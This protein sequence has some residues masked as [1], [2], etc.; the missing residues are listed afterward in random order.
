[1]RRVAILAVGL[2]VAV[3]ALW[4][5]LRPPTLDVPPPS[6]TLVDVTVV[7]P[8]RERRQVRTLQVRGGRVAWLGDGGI[9]PRGDVLDPERPHD[10]DPQRF[11]GMYVLPGL[12]DMHVHQPPATPLGDVE[13]AALLF[14]LHGVTAVR[15]TGSFD[16]AILETQRAIRLGEFPGP[17]IFAC[18]PIL[19]GD[20]P[21][22]SGSRVVRDAAE[23]RAAVDEL[24]AKKVDCV[25]V[26]DRLS[27]EALAAVREAAERHGLPVIGH[28]PAQVPFS[29]ARLADVQHLTGV[30]EAG[31]QLTPARER[32]I[33][34]ASAALGIAHTPTLVF[35]ERVSQLTD[36]RAQLA[37]PG[38]RLLPRYYREVL[39]N[40]EHDARL[41]GLSAGDWDGL[42]ET[43]ANAKRLV[44]A[45]H[46][47]GVEIHVGTDAMNPFVVPGASLHEEMWELVDAG[48][49]P[50]EVWI[51]ATRTAGKALGQPTLGT[52]AVGAP[53]DLL[54]FREDPTRDLNALQT[55]EAV[56]A[57]GRLYPRSTLQEALG[58]W[59]RHFD[60]P[61]Y[62]AVTM[63]LARW[64]I[65]AR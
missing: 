27:P 15:D 33:L 34:T 41:R 7:N 60:D 52:I 50:E 51:A 12:I 31:E 13:L 49:T 32:A 17:R 63:R 30:V 5:L 36:Y 28:V 61:V 10:P 35:L 54:V 6:T 53:A 20:P 40:P 21:F 29:E 47:A 18:G 23:A 16:G 3:A 4:S 11:A 48:L 24:A 9:A 8:G 38:A 58:R 26:Y 56:V 45:M 44:K 37:D 42:R 62:D 64:L 57:A 39:W 14:L 65:P 19:D 1:V 46:D 59:Q 43:L 25:K 22:W 55:L 2:V